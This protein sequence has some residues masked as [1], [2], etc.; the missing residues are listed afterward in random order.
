MHPI[1]DPRPVSDKTGSG[2]KVQLWT[3]E[4]AYCTYGGN[5][6]PYV[7]S[8]PG[9]NLLEPLTPYWRPSSRSTDIDLP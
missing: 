7:R 4:E 3:A 9:F 6:G 1:V 5:A 8:R 2:V